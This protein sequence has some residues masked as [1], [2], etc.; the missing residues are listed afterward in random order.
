MKKAP[1]FEDEDVDDDDIGDIDEGE[2]KDMR[3]NY[4]T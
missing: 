2:K 3:G 1:S 4:Q